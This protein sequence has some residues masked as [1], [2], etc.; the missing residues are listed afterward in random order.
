MDPEDEKRSSLNRAA[1][2]ALCRLF[3]TGIDGPKF[4]SIFAGYDVEIGLLNNFGGVI[5][6]ER[7]LIDT[8]V[9]GYMHR[10]EGIPS[11]IVG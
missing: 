1:E 10:D 9:T 8:F 11:G 4:G 2:A 5:R 3:R 7:D 6:F